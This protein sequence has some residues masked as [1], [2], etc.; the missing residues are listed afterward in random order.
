[1][2]QKR[3]PVVLEHLRA[4]LS[5]A[6]AM[7]QSVVTQCHSIP[8]GDTQDIEDEI[9]PPFMDAITTAQE[10][11]TLYTAFFATLRL[12]EQHL[13]AQAGKNF[14]TA[15]ELADT[16]VRAAGLPFRLAHQVAATLVRTMAHDGTASSEWSVEK[17]QV[18]ARQVL[19]RERALTAE[20]LD[21][22]VDPMR[23][24]AVRSGLGGAAPQATAALLDELRTRSRPRV[25]CP[26]RTSPAPSPAPPSTGDRGHRQTLT[27]KGKTLVRISCAFVWL[28]VRLY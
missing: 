17:L 6:L 9:M 8:Y 26:G 14:T 23:F 2:P 18:A 15:T 13:R 1:M 11:V 4:R 10:C 27:L 3:N 7:A 19:G 21:Q 16:L 25:A 22:A 5:R 28:R 12:N 24:V 20:Q